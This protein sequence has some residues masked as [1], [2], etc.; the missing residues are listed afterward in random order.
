V[1]SGWPE[2]YVLSKKV[3][4]KK[5][6]RRKGAVWGLPLLSKTWPVSLTISR[7][8]LG[9]TAIW[10]SGGSARNPCV[11]MVVAELMPGNVAM[12]LPD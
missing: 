11:E 12:K 2:K 1:L 5:S 8:R 6:V 4:E 3:K 9:P 7:I 10:V